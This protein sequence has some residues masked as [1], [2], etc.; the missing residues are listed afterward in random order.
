MCPHFIF[1][2]PSPNLQLFYLKNYMKST[3]SLVARSFL[4]HGKNKEWKC[5]VVV[6]KSNIAIWRSDIAFLAVPC[7]TLTV[8]LWFDRCSKH[9]HL[10]GSICYPDYITWSWGIRDLILPFQKPLSRSSFHTL[11]VTGVDYGQLWTFVI[12]RDCQYGVVF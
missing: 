1:S 11:Y 2:V 3:Y 7:R 9:G 10:E 5:F 12:G 4:H 6:S 8:P